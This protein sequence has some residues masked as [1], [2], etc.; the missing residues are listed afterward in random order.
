MSNITDASAA[1]AIFDMK[2]AYTVEKDSIL[3]K[4]ENTIVDMSKY[5]QKFGSYESIGNKVPNGKNTQ[6][7]IFHNKVKSAN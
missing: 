1:Y 4:L 7:I 6:P 3:D 5:K 2:K